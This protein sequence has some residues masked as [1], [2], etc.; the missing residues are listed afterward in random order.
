[1][2]HFGNLLLTLNPFDLQEYLLQFKLLYTG[3]RIVVS[4]MVHLLLVV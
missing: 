2:S 3:F 1:M 4:Y